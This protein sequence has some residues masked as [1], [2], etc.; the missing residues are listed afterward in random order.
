MSSNYSQRYHSISTYGYSAL[1]SLSRVDAI[2]VWCRSFVLVL[3]NNNICA[4]Y[5]LLGYE[6]VSC[7]RFISGGCWADVVLLIAGVTKLSF[8]ATGSTRAVCALGL[9]QAS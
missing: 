3:S 2:W 9:R 6:A 7:T 4:A 8:S 1:D 5:L